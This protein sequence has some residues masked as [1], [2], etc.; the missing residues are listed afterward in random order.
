MLPLILSKLELAFNL[1]DCTFGIDRYKQNTARA[2]MF[3][4]SG[5][6]NMLTIECSFFGS[7]R[8]Q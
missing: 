2:F 5:S 7:N 4:T 6:V 8:T 1:A 3:Y